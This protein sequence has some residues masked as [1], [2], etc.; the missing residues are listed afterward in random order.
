MT[1]S[2]PDPLTEAPE[3]GS[4]SGTRRLAAIAAKESAEVP[5]V[6]PDQRRNEAPRRPT[7]PTWMSARIPAAITVSM[8]VKPRLFP[9]TLLAIGDPPSLLR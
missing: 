2:C 9:R 4:I 1:T 6:P 8:I 3:P 5:L 7:S